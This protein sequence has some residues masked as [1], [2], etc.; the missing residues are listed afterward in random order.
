M[1]KT[2]KCNLRT[3]SRFD[4]FLK[5]EGI[6]EEVVLRAEKEILAWKIQQ[7]MK[8]KK[9]TV[10]ALALKMGTS[11]AAVDRILNPRNPSITLH[12]L[13]K[14][15]HALGKRWKFDLVEA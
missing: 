11:R 10:S 1:S 9:M 13:E 15:A 8:E 3:G 2:K 4:T 14:T 12:T 6:Y 7:A 5:E